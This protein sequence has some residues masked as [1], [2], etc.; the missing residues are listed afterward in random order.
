MRESKFKGLNL[1]ERLAILPE[2]SQQEI[3]DRCAEYIISEWKDTYT[4]EIRD[5]LDTED[6]KVK[7]I[8]ENEIDVCELISRFD[9]HA[10]VSLKLRFLGGKN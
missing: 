3:L 6:F 5:L 4:D 1:E 8:D 10:K 7:D 2:S 9:F